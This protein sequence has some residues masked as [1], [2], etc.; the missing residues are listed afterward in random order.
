MVS[1]EAA[2]APNLPPLF[3]GEA[4]GGDPLR[5]AVARACAGTE[6]GL[7]VHRLRPEQ[8]SAALVLAPEAPLA[9]AMAMVFAAANGFAD[10]FGAL[11]PSEIAAQF[12]WPGGIRI[13]G[14]RCGGLRAAASSRDPKA[15]PDWL[16]IALDMP[17]RSDA[18]REPGEMPDR[19]TLVEEGCTGLA[20]MQLL[21]SW[22]RH[23]LVWIHDWLETGMTRLHAHWRAR[24]FALGRDV[25][26][27]LAGERHAGRFV[28]LDERGGMLLGT[29]GRTRLLPLTLML[30]EVRC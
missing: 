9:D 11:A 12:D 19:T 25:A 29:G 24:A 4:T 18:A 15:E 2:D 14:A 1:S 22:S 23:M 8:L 30:E 27:T 20:P 21:E 7:I 5:V 28:G 26:F 17:F 3:S 13:N 16:V 10:A 6:P